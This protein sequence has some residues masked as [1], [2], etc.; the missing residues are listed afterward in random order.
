MFM[1][2][3]REK[4]NGKIDDEDDDVDM[5]IVFFSFTICPTDKHN[6]ELHHVIRWLRCW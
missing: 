1:H 3:Q 4:K 5:K 2:K 6:G